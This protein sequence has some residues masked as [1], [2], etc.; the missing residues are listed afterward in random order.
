MKTKALIGLLATGLFLSGCSKFVED[1]DVSP[2]YPGE[3]NAALLTTNAQVALFATYNGQLART[4]SI[5]TQQLAGT[6]AQMID[7]ASYR[8]YEGDIQNEWDVIYKDGLEACRDLINNYSDGNPH[9]RGIGQVLECMFLGVA[10]D[11]WGDVP[12]TNAIKGTDDLNPTFDT[13]EDVIKYIQ[14][15]LDAA[16][17]NLKTDAA[18]NS[19]TP[20]TDDLV[21]GGDAA[22]WIKAAYTLKA[23]YAM[24]ITHKSSTASSD[25]LSALAN[26]IA[27]SDDDM[28]AAF[29]TKGTELN[30]WFAFETARPGYLRMG[31]PFVDE[32]TANNDPRLSFYAA[33]D[34][35]DIYRGAV[36]GSGDATASPIGSYLQSL[37]F[38]LIS[39]VEAKFIEA[40]AQ[41]ANDKGKS[42]EAFNDAVKASLMAVT[43]ANDSAFVAN[44]AS[45][46]AGSI[47]LDKIYAQK[48]VALFGQIEA[49]NEWRKGD[50]PVRTPNPQGVITT[51]PVRYPTPLEERLYNTNAVVVHDL[52]QKVWWDN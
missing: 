45:E 13:Q 46:T 51:I 34:T 52:S 20:S 16:I 30:T 38:P 43:G 22:A 50:I 9:Y 8:L 12:N 40:E 27:S 47:N 37:S 1:Y 36:I 33:K 29:G 7:H 44:V 15:N 4:T 2:N 19:L 32:L 31:K 39:Y 42:A 18:A 35:G 14:S 28:M 3:V 5:W 17:T 26:G 48:H 23:R 25:A 10:T 6:D 11:L 41:F 24:R 21:Y 49:Y